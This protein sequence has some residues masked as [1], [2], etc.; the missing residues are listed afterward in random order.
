MKAKTKD[1]T[2]FM[3]KRTGY[4]LINGEY[5]LAPFYCDQFARLNAEEAGIRKMLEIIIDHASA[6]LKTIEE[7]KKRVFEDIG[8]DLGID[9]K[10]IGWNYHHGSGVLK[11]VKADKTTG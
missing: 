1:T 3:G 10:T 7:R 6:D 4:E 11:Q 9:L 8:E 5:H 2:H